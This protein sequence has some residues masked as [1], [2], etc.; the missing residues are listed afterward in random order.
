MA[1]FK[2]S[3]PPLF[4]TEITENKYLLLEKTL[5]ACCPHL[6]T[7]ALK[8]SQPRTPGTGQPRRAATCLPV[9]LLFVLHPHVLRKGIVIFVGVP[10]DNHIFADDAGASA[11]ATW[12]FH[13]CVSDLVCN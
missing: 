8:F 10:V 5:P 12:I 13:G 6:T 4:L 3:A 9:E 7:P 1:A 11:A 2:R